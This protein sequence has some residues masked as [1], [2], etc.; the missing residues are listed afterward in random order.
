LSLDQSVKY[1]GALLGA[2]IG[3]ALGWPQENRSNRI[4]SSKEKVPLYAFQQWS[5]RSGGRYY[6]HEEI[7]NPGE[8][9]DDS[10]LLIATAR[11]LLYGDKWSRH[12]GVVELPS[13]VLY[14]RGGG[15]A[16][17]RAAESWGR[18]LPP[19][20]LVNGSQIATQKY[21]EAGGNGVA[22][23]I[24]PNVF[25]SADLKDLRQQIMIN[26]IY[27][28]GHPKALLGAVLYGVA[29]YY[30]VNLEGRLDYGALIDQL[31][32]SFD[33]WK[34]MPQWGSTSFNEWWHSANSVLNKDYKS[35]WDQTAN[36]LKE[37]LLVARD[38]IK[39]GLLDSTHSTLERLNCFDPKTN[40]SGTVTALAS[41]YLASKYISD[42]INGVVEAAFLDKA[43]TDTL[44][45]MV[46][47]L[48]GAVHEDGWYRPEWLAV[49]DI[50]YVRL[51]TH[52]V[53]REQIP[54]HFWSE[55]DN[56]EFKEHVKTL[57]LGGITKFGPF[58]RAKVIGRINNKTNVKNTQ[59]STA[60][61]ITDEGQSLFIKVISKTIESTRTES[62]ETDVGFQRLENASDHI[63]LSVQDFENISKIMSGRFSSKRAFET[64][65]EVLR[66]TTGDSTL[67]QI[68][69]RIVQP[70][71]NLADARRLVD[72]IA[73]KANKNSK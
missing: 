15:G 65:A 36:E 40:G 61:L 34:D 2:V 71:L 47:G 16:T 19:W 26:G 52:G 38:S 7:I 29:M 42:P 62:K 46:G 24:L 18:G 70:G 48:L 11:S 3:D 30:L 72:Y 68:S 50:E 5:R 44:A 39:L 21:F 32:E 59:I 9:S 25:N 23:R 27:T 28:H 37:G 4:G 67:E 22:M 10:Q 17:L 43:D 20:K 64:V 41:I 69:T 12:F 14:Q 56:K 45:S 58:T 51:I 54:V 35:L 49:Q 53:K 73:E 60:K 63:I 8:Y 1:E 33:H 66:L 31:I 6:S 13:W 55:R 57:E